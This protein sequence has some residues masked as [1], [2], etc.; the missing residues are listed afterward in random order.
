[1]AIDPSI[2]LGFRQPEAPSQLNMLAQAMQL[3][4]MQ[5]Q[6]QMGVLDMQ[7]R[8]AAAAERE[9]LRNYLAGG[10][11]LDTPEGQAGLFKAAPTMAAKIQKDRLDLKATQSQIGEREAQTRV[12]EVEL[13]NKTAEQFKNFWGQVQTPQQA[14]QLIAQAY[15]HPILGKALPGTAEEA[16]ARIPTDPAQFGQ[17]LQRQ[18]LGADEFIKRNTLTLEQSM[19]LDEQ[20]RSNRAS[21]G[22]TARGQD[23]ADQR[24]R[25]AT[26]SA[27]SKPFEVTGPEGNPILVQQDKNGKLVPVTDFQ[28][29]GMGPTK[30]TED[31]GKA[32]GWL[33]QANN[34]FSNMKNALKK[35]PSAAQP[36]VNDAIAAI[37]SFGVGEALANTMRGAERQK[38]LQGASSLSEALLR[39]ATGAGVN[40][41]EAIQKVKELTPVFGES[42]ET[43]KQK[44]DSIPLYIE[45]LK[46]RAGPGAKQLPG[47]VERATAGGGASGSWDNQPSGDDPLG[48]RKP[49]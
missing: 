25:E 49:K 17:Y 32:T 11:N 40:R 8:Q 46:V 36:G 7:D 12:R 9:A 5:R 26:Q 1:M 3:Q 44:M 31:Q 35:N 42:D 48:I 41:D 6:N 15:A 37:P 27:M 21:E 28:P 45:A 33:V 4:G 24:A 10:A 39:A 13:V 20:K 19:K 38:F 34:A 2:A 14:Q 29:K 30:L 43:T 47:I 18:I 22:L 16:A 23:M